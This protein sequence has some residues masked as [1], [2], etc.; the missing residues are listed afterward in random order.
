[1]AHNLEGLTVDELLE[2][3]KT[4]REMVSGY[5][6]RMGRLTVHQVSLLKSARAELKRVR[7]V[8][9]RR[10]VTERMF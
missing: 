4:T 7:A 1:M 2:I 10:L 3:K 5:E 8:L 9:K 6:A